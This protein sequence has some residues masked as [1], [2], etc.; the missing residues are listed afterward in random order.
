MGGVVG[1]DEAVHRVHG[2]VD[3]DARL[4]EGDVVVEDV[5]EREESPGRGLVVVGL[6]EVG[7]VGAQGGEGGVEAVVGEVAL[8]EEGDLGGGDLLFGG[9]AAA[10]LRVAGSRGGGSGWRRHGLLV[11]VVVDSFQICPSLLLGGGTL[12]L[13]TRPRPR[14]SGGRET[15]IASSPR[16]EN[17]ARG[18]PSRHLRSHV[19]WAVLPAPPLPLCGPSSPVLGCWPVRFLVYREWLVVDDFF[20]VSTFGG[21]EAP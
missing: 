6:E 15:R 10:L 2:G 17:G 9:T 12:I 14:I 20:S 13:S 18:R 8:D 1:G 19:G 16:K 21:E 11:V 4:L 7:G 5:G 3:G